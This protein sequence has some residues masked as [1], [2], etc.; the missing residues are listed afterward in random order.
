MFF[1]NKTCNKMQLLLLSL[2]LLWPEQISKCVL[3]QVHISTVL[4]AVL[5]EILT[6]QSTY[7]LLTQLLA[8]TTLTY[9]FL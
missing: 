7:R 8:F 9:S 3:R 2:L 5:L 4:L 1:E 6:L